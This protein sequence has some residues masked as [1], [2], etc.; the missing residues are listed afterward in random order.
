ML[1]HRRIL[2][3]LLAAV[4]I[5]TAAGCG[6]GKKQESTAPAAETTAA[7]PE[8]G[9]ETAPV[10]STAA[11]E[12]TAE[13]K[14]TEAP[15]TPE[16]TEAPTIPET[17]EAPT[18]APETTP[19]P[20]STADWTEVYVESSEPDEIL[21][22]D[23][24]LAENWVYYGEGGDRQIDVFMVCTT[25]DSRSS[26]N[27]FDL[28]EKLK[29]RFVSALDAEKGLYDETARVYAP[30]YR[31]MS[32]NAYKLPTAAFN[33]ARQI[34]YRD[35]ADAFRWYLDHENNG[36]GLIL[37]GFSQGAD[38]VLELLKE[39]YGGDELEA[40]KLRANL[41]AAYAIG[42]RVTASMT[43]EYPQIV[44]ASGESDTGCVISYDCEDGTLGG[45]VIIPMGMQALSI[46]PLNWKTDSTP[47]DKSLNLGAVMQ[48][49]GEP[50]PGLCGCYIGK[51]GELVVTDVTPADYPPGPD[52][53]QE[54]AYHLY[55]Y[56]FFY[57]N[58]KENVAVRANRWL[59]VCEMP[60]G[61]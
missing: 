41:V 10:T 43:D 46:N 1:R 57:T 19:A 38:L 22:M 24:S 42:W 13:E 15:T 3:L 6:K 30:Y 25:V 9:T 54:G 49:D 28:N 59:S 4:M 23:Y 61:N 60:Q 55:D 33:E 34:A 11:P 31:Q 50:Q 8:T 16:A 18:T 37:A 58:L 35:V 27:A 44:P 7:A 21:P 12:T 47:A 20:E 17:T 29:A 39:F 26:H 48:T 45:S 5:C 14:T 2:A 53:F 56:K 36:R 51:R 40:V 32:I 52:L